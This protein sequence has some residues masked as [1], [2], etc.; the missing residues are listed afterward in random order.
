[1]ATA[2]GKCRLLSQPLLRDKGKKM[3]KII[4]LFVSITFLTACSSVGVNDYKG[5]KPTLVLEDYLNGDLEAQGM[6]QD[7][8]GKVV[9]RFYVKM[10]ASW[11]GNVGTL[12]EDFIYSDGTKGKRVWT[13][14]KTGENKYKGTASDVIGEATGEV[15]GNAFRWFYTLDLPVGDKSYHVHFDD[16]MYLMDDKIMLNKSKMSKFGFYLGEVTLAFVKK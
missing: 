9:K 16:W 14:T 7:R 6:F 4:A 13:V 2:Q 11:V 1:M 3:K 12:D 15:Q 10:K 5:E 8:S